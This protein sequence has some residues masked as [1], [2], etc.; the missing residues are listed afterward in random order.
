MHF[1]FSLTPLLTND[2]SLY[3]KNL[4]YIYIHANSVLIVKNSNGF[5]ECGQILVRCMDI[6]CLN[7]RVSECMYIW[8][9][10]VSGIFPCIKNAMLTSSDDAK[11][12]DRNKIC[13]PNHY[14][15]IE[16]PEFLVVRNETLRS[17]IDSGGSRISQTGQPQRWGCQPIV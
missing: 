6:Y 15:T 11:C 5:M 1:Y 9:D 2:F 17:I 8:C 14:F 12:Q 13:V 7:A 16:I 3:H 10:N 4:Y